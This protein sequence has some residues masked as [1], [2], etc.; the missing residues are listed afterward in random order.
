MR[1]WPAG[2][3]PSTIRERADS[4]ISTAAGETSDI[5]DS[6]EEMRIAAATDG[7]SKIAPG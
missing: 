1:A 2:T 5:T 4:E 6:G 3:P 7:P